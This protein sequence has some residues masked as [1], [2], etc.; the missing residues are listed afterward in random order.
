MATQSSNSVFE[1]L[2]SRLQQTP[3]IVSKVKTVYQWHITDGK[4]VTASWTMD[5]K[6]G[7]GEIKQG[8]AEK[9]D[10]TLTLSEADFIAIVEGRL[11]PQQAFLQKK[12]KI[13]GNLMASQKLQHILKSNSPQ[14]KL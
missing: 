14:A 6:N 2:G 4:N 10:C 7:N 9:A 5:L 11:N 13:T 12:L 1:M 8:T 3:D